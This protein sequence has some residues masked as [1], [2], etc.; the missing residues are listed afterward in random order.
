MC[1]Y[2]KNK[3][4]FLLLPI[5]VVS[6]SSLCAFY[7]TEYTNTLKI[8]MADITDIPL[9]FKILFKVSSTFSAI[10]PIILFLFLYL[11]SEIMLNDFFGENVKKETLLNI[12]GVSFIPM[13]AHQYFFWYNILS[14]CNTANIK[15]IQ[16]LANMKFMFDLTLESF[17]YINLLCWGLVYL[18]PILYFIYKDMNVFSTF[19]SFLIPSSLTIFFYFIIQ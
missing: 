18:I 9:S 5:V 1:Q 13:L 6:L 17:E 8:G 7:L 16:D 4:I 2:L 14:Y 11:S 15:R 19:I 10:I 12:L 3:N